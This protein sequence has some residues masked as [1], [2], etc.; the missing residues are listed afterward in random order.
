MVNVTEL[1]QVVN[2]VAADVGVPGAA[3]GVIHDGIARTF[4]TG[5]T[6]VDAPVP[7]NDRTLFMI[8][9]TTKTVTATAI[10]S[11]VDEGAVE[12]DS[13]VIDIMPELALASREAHD[14]LTLRHLLTH[15]GGFEGDV[16]DSDDWDNDAIARS[17]VSYGELAQYTRP[18]SA[19]SYSN[20]GFRLV[21]RLLE[22]ITGQPYETAVRERV[23]GP[24]GMTDSFYFP[25]EVFS[26]R[27]AVGHSIGEDGSASVAHTWGLGRSG[28]AEGGLASSIADQLKYMQFHLDGTA[29][30]QAPLS[31]AIRSEMQS[32]QAAAA[33]PFDGVGL[34]WLLV[35][36]FGT[37]AVTHGGNIA[38]IQ[39]S[40]M[41]LLPQDGFA[42]TVLANSGAGGALGD[43]V[44]TWCFENLLG[45]A[46]NDPF[47]P[48][49]LTDAE[50]EPFCGTW[51]SGTW[52]MN[53]TPV[54]GMLRAAFFL[55]DELADDVKLLPPPMSLAFCASDEIIHPQSPETLFGRFE[56]DDRGLVTRL[57]CQGRALRRVD[58][59]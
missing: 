5:T 17:V 40:T 21:G 31:A 37:T 41:T 7:V 1:Q 14:I 50:L 43:A 3:V 53:L 59:A 25:W 48:T 10:L 47:S 45:R 44:T 38:G 2:D 52:G 15:T 23:L 8:G 9:S 34:P 12:L 11:L 46:A 18:G 58:G 29:P 20:A 4:T 13:R 32:R 57:L 26:R 55:S 54:D 27:H 19:F 22:V 36:M 56:R 49:L 16:A 33:P 28:A 51:D 24:L 6:S 39:R 42:V 35:N 30:G